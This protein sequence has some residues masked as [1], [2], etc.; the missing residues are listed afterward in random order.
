MFQ[1]DI[2][3]YSCHFVL[4]A[5][6]VVVLDSYLVSQAVVSVEANVNTFLS[7]EMEIEENPVRPLIQFW[8]NLSL[9]KE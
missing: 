5:I 2:K 8:A 9:Q 3:S 6:S 4:L 1:Y 7:D